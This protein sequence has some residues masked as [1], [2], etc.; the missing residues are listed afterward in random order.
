MF[1]VPVTGP[2]PVFQPGCAR[3]G[4]GSR[5]GPGSRRGSREETGSPAW[6]WELKKLHTNRPTAES[7]RFQGARERN[8]GET[9]V[10]GGGFGA[11]PPRSGNISL[12][13]AGGKCLTTCRGRGRMSEGLEAGGNQSPGSWALKAPGSRLRRQEGEE[14]RSRSIRRAWGAGL[15]TLNL[16]LP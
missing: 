1:H 3:E 13:E 8:W 7:A 5:G 12:G 6:C 10:G 16:I 4:G 14:D 2:T 9:V 11:G 15:R